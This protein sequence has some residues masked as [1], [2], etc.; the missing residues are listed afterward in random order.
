MKQAFEKLKAMG[1]NLETT[2]GNCTGYMKEID[3][4]VT[5]SKAQ[6]LITSDEADAQAPEREDEPI[7][8]GFYDCTGEKT[9][10]LR[11]KNLAAFLNAWTED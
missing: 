10:A 2:G 7:I 8:V 4:G 6:V 1:F 9:G 5:E 3:N 11:F